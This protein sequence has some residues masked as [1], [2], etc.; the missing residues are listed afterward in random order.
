VI[1]SDKELTGLMADDLGLA[2]NPGVE[3]GLPV[4]ADGVRTI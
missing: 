3:G 4:H 2:V 1:S